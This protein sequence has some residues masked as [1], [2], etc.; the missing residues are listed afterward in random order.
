M[1]IPR[2]LPKEQQLRQLPGLWQKVVEEE[3]SKPALSRFFDDA[4]AASLE[5]SLYN[6]LKPDHR[7]KMKMCLE[8]QG[9]R[10]LELYAELGITATN[11]PAMMERVCEL[12]GTGC[13]WN[14]VMTGIR[15]Y[16]QGK[17]R[18]KDALSTRSLWNA[19]GEGNG[20]WQ[21]ALETHGSLSAAMAACSTDYSPVSASPI[22]VAF[23]LHV[24]LTTQTFEKPGYSVREICEQ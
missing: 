10:L 17:R 3:Q 22:G 19:L 8:A 5:D 7:A 18:A 12:L 16:G 13:P 6:K 15:H 1:D 24:P 20:K 14:F 2:R 4:T 11:S 21:A 23:V 9:V